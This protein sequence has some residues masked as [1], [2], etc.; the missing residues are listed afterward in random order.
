MS[1]LFV[2]AGGGA[3]AEGLIVS[4]NRI[5]FHWKMRDGGGSQGG[6]GAP[7]NERYELKGRGFDVGRVQ[8]AEVAAGRIPDFN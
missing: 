6:G 1:A 2:R 3:R 7:L 8:L 4:I 5:E